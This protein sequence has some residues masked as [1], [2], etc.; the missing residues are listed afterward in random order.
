MNCL[1]VKKIRKK[2]KGYLK[3]IT[4]NPLYISDAMHK[5]TIEL[6]QEGIKASAATAMGG[7]GAGGAFDY[8]F[9]VPVEEI[10]LTFDKP[11]MFIIRDKKSGEVWFMGTVYNPLLYS[12]DLTKIPGRYN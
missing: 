4:D 9:D 6:T 1:V 10:D 12:E 5:A 7:F 3:N 11:Y 8:L 2:V